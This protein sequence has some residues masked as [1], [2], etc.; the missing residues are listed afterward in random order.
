MVVRI[1]KS[2]FFESSGTYRMV[3][4]AGM[5]LEKVVKY[6]KDNIK[7]HI[8]EGNDYKC[9]RRMLSIYVM[10]KNFSQVECLIQ[11]FNTDMGKLYEVIC[12]LQAVELVYEHYDDDR[13][14]EKLEKYTKIL[15]I[16]FNVKWIPK[17]IEQYKKDLNKHAR[18]IYLGLKDGKY[19]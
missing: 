12:I 19:S 14:V 11:G 9:L 3:P 7:K 18:N 8:R 5:S 6:L 10:F 15:D 17:I 16:P 1:K 4:V 13:T 2:K